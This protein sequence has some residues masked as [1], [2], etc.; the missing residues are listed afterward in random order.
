MSKYIFLEE[1]VSKI[2]E[3]VWIK[4]WVAARRNMGKI[5]FLDIRDRS[6]VVQVVGVGNDLDQHS[7]D[8]LS[9]V[10]LGWLVEINGIVQKRGDKQK[11][12]VVQLDRIEILVLNIFII[13]ESEA[14]PFEVEQNT[15]ELSEGMRL[16]Y[17]YLDIRSE[18][19][20]NNLKKRQEINLFLRNY[21]SKQ[22]FWEIETPY[23]TK[24]TPEGAR[25]FVIPSRI[26]KGNF[27]VLPQSPQQFKQLLMV[28]G[29]ERYYQVV[30]CFR[31]EDQRG[32]RQPEFTQFDLEM[33]FIDQEDI[34]QLI[35]K[36]M[37]DLVKELFPN[38]RMQQIPFP[39][40]TYMEAQKLYKSDKPDLRTEQDPNLLAFGWII[41]FPLFEYSDTEK[42]MVSVHHPF[43]RPKND[44]INMMEEKPEKVRAEAYDLVL[45]GFEVGGGS[46]RIFE[47]DLQ[48]KVFQ[49]LGLNETEISLRFGHLLEA[50]SFAPP[51][52][53]G[54][55]LGLDRLIAILL[56]EKNIREVIAFPK[57]GDAKDLMMGAPSEISKEVLNELHIKGV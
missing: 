21:F 19:V 30:R 56:N 41:D 6:G 52:H 18:R 47:R 26:H 42:K 13:S 31:D 50:F 23:L 43:T 34:L 27:Y 9:N 46:L 32:D 3:T 1:A 25:E 48:K 16:K 38:L 7:I 24:G 11:S 55:A 29:I 28:A 4:G 20:K 45:N 10:R 39:R 37:I 33:S 12:F 22:G 44:D 40:L 14:L 51:P 35:E 54:I 36:A 15:L 2:G 8:V 5:V 49:I 53:G 17:R 57:T